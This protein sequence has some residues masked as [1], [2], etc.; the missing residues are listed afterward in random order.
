MRQHVELLLMACMIIFSQA[1]WAGGPQIRFEKESHDY[2]GIRYGDKVTAEFPFV[3]SGD[4]TLIIDR[5]EATCG[6]TKTIKGASQI[7]AGGASKIVAEFDTTGLKA[8]RKEKSVFVHSNDPEKP[9]VKLTLQAEVIKD[10]NIEPPSLTKQL[11]GFMQQISFPMR[12]S[13]SSGAPCTLSQVV[14]DSRQVHAFMEPEKV[15][16]APG[17]TV[18]FTIKMKLNKEESRFYYMG[19]LVIKTDHP[20]EPEIE[21]RYLVK[22]NKP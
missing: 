6:C 17:T 5:L 21:M 3:N 4:R 20:R 2:G 16:A 22:I 10:V 18:A 9:I 12:V 8:G 14:D 7:P 15:T 11:P 13:N 1:A 19:R